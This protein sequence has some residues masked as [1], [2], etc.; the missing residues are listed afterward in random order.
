MRHKA[1]TG[2]TLTALGRFILDTGRADRVLHVKS[3]TE[4]PLLT[5]AHISATAADVL[6]ASQSRYGPAAP[7][8]HVNRLLDEGL[9]FASIANPCDIAAIRSLARV[10]PRVDRQVVY[11]LSLF[12]GGVPTGQTAENIV[13]YHGMRPKDVALFRW[14]GEGWPGD[15]VVESRDGLRASM[16]CAQTWYAPDV[17]WKYDIQFRCKIR[18]DA[19]GEH[20]DVTAPD[21]WL[22]DG[23][24]RLVDDAPGVNIAI[25]RTECGQQLV[26]DAATAG[27]LVIEPLSVDA[28]DLMHADHKPRKHEYVARSLGLAV[29]GQARLKARGFRSWRNAWAAG[30]P[31]NLRAFFGT[32]RRALAGRNREPLQ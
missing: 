27:A 2:E 16:T 31:V 18:P 24:R 5:D 29:T 25:T 21:G 32:L 17:P 20:A 15:T 12:C 30:L 22:M 10:D 11:L 23:A 8:V 7:L 14:R 1:A 3:S 13:G 19:T 28:L 9:R 6:D 26:L 4:N